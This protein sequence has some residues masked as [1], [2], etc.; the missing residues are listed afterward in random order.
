MLEVLAEGKRILSVETELPYSGP[1]SVI[2]TRRLV[3]GWY[4]IAYIE[5][6][7]PQGLGKIRINS[8]LDSP[9]VGADTL[10][11]LLW[12]EYLHLYLKQGHTATFREWERKWPGLIE[13]D[14]FLDNLNER[15]GV[16]YW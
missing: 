15:F 7:V 5:Q 8:L 9:D 3:K 16:Q 1:G 13:A 14:R 10:R 4:G 12:H 2:W 6:T 11:F